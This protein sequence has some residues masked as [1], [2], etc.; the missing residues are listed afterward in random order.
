MLEHEAHVAHE[1]AADRVAAAVDRRQVL[2]VAAPRDPD[3]DLGALVDHLSARRTLLEHGVAIL[4]ALAI[5]RDDAA[6]PGVLEQDARLVER[7]P[8]DVGDADDAAVESFG[9]HA[10]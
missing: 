7:P 10:T 4:V 3:R 2:E 9:D 1:V 8:D 6:E 5:Q